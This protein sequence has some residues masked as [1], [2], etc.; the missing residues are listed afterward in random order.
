MSK[1][2]KVSKKVNTCHQCGKQMEVVSYEE[3]GASIMNVTC[4]F[5]SECPNYSLV[6]ISIEGMYKLEKQIKEDKNNE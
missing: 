5:N 3:K 1:A 6:Q 4:C 2:K